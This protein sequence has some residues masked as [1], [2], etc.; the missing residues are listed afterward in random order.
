MATVPP[1]AFATVQ[2][3]VFRSG[4]PVEVNFGF[5]R[6]LGLRTVLCLNP[7]AA[8]DALNRF[9]D[10]QGVDLVTV[11][12]GE[13]QEPFGELDAAAMRRVVAML[14]DRERHPLLL[15]CLTGKSCTG[16]AVACFRTTQGWALSAALDEYARFVQGAHSLMDLQFIEQFALHGSAWR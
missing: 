11:P 6:Q 15:H 1:L 5:L 12:V 9:C 8:T 13:N 14:V 3:G 2:P 10:E 7:A 16:C 4:A